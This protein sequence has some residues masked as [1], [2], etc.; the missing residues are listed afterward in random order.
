MCISIK[1][2]GFIWTLLGAIAFAGLVLIILNNDINIA[3]IGFGFF[4]S[5]GLLYMGLMVLS[6]KAKDTLGMGVISLIYPVLTLILHFPGV[7]ESEIK[8]MSGQGVIIILLLALAGIL[9]LN[10]RKKY[11]LY[12]SERG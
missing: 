4:L 9:A 1:L 2:A 11:K 5:V 6:G 12:I 3:M 7:G 10:G 8:A